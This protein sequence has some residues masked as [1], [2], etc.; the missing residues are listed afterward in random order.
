[1][2]AETANTDAPSRR[3]SPIFL[4]PALAGLVVLAAFA[5]PRLKLLGLF[6]AAIG[7]AAGYLIACLLPAGWSRPRVIVVAALFVPLTLAGYG[8]GSFLVWRHGR[9]KE[10]AANLIAQPG[11]R[12][13]LDRIQSAKPPADE[14]EAAFLAAYRDRMNPPPGVYLADRLKGLPVRVPKASAVL[15]ASAEFAL[16]W[17]AGIVAAVLAVERSGRQQTPRRRSL[18]A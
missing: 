1:M 16:G 9:A 8:A 14:V 4:A 5:P 3:S 13:I 10:V 15:I 18:T 2:S 17:A 12:G 7:A 11:G 6:P